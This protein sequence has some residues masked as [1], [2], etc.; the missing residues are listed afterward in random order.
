MTWFFWL[1]L[2]AVIVAIVAVTGAQP[3][4]GRRVAGTQ[5][6]TVARTVLIVLA[7]IVAYFVYRR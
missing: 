3:R 7:L 2:I 6:M 4:E 1:I 5:L